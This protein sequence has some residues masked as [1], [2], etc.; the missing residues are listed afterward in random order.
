MAAAITAVWVIVVALLARFA[1]GDLDGAD[2]GVLLLGATVPVMLLWAVLILRTDIAKLRSEMPA[3]DRPEMHERAID[4]QTSATVARLAERQE[5]TER[6][7]AA[8]RK[9]C[10]RGNPAPERAEE[11][12]STQPPQDTA[13]DAAISASQQTTRQPALPLDR[14]TR[15]DLPDE[16][17]DWNATV[18]ALDFPRDERDREGFRAM[19]A[20]QDDRQVAELLRA[21]EDVLNLLAQDGI[22]VDDLAPGPADP[23]A[24]RRFAAGT[25]GAG[26]EGLAG[27]ADEGAEGAVRAR[28]R[29]DPVMRDAALHFMRR[30]DHVLRLG[31]AREDDA[32]LL[33]IVDSRTGRAF[34]LLALVIGSFD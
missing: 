28:M 31:A 19:K 10:S 32:L 20:V 12:T 18:R 34:M 21:S 16:A 6:A 26:R 30:F 4:R 25:R 23:D 7:V 5:M 9:D 2:L 14:G 3:R 13:G 17:R 33:G 29:A 11:T 1:T 15:P 24:W 22:Y 8:L 27:I